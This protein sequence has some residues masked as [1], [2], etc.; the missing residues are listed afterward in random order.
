[1]AI[2]DKMAIG[3]I[4]IPPFIIMSISEVIS[5]AGWVGKAGPAARV[6]FSVSETWVKR[7]RNDVISDC[8]NYY[9]S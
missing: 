2:I 3:I 7:K 9:T 4:M 1:M 5:G 6:L 8:L